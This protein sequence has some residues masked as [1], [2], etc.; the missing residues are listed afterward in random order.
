[1]EESED[2]DDLLTHDLDRDLVQRAMSVATQF[3]DLEAR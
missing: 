1:M 2:A 3:A